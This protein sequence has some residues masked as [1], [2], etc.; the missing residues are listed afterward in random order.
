[1]LNYKDHL[2]EAYTNKTYRLVQEFE[3]EDINNVRAAV[4]KKQNM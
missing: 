1:M 2:E 3:D 4:C